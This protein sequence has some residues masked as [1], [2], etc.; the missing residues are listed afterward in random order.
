MTHGTSRTI[1]VGSLARVEG[2]GALA[3]HVRGGRVVEARLDIYP[4]DGGAIASS[5]GAG[6]DVTE[7]EDRVVE[8][9]VPHSTALHA[10]MAQV[11][12]PYLVGPLA[13]YSLNADRLSALAREAAAAA[14]LGDVCRNPFRSIVVRSVEVLYACDEALRLLERYE[15]PARA[16]VAVEPRAGRGC[17]WTEAPRG[18]LYHRYDLADD[19]TILAARIVRPT[20]QNQRAIEDDMRAVVEQGLDLPRHDLSHLCERAIRNHDPCISCATHF[21]EL[22]VDDEG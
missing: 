16:A 7:F 22:T 14:G 8:E 9:Q 2:E 6:F 15:A 12:G 11:D 3:V 20:S 5:G 4:L 1:K 21:L 17:G 10:R 18:L 19:G 13:R